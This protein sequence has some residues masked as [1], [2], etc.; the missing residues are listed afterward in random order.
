MATKR[1][2]KVAKLDGNASDGKARTDPKPDERV[3]A[4]RSTTGDLLALVEVLAGVDRI[5]V[6]QLSRQMGVPVATA[7]RMLRVLERSGFV[8]QL[9][10]SKEYRLTLKLFELGCQVASRTTMRDVAAVEIERLAQQTGTATNVGVLVDNYVLYLV[11]V[12]TDELI[13]LNLRPGSRAPA[14]CTAMGKA[15]LAAETRPLRA[16]VGDGPYAA[17]T[18]HSITTYKGL[19]AELEKVKRQGYAVDR[20]ELSLGLWCIAAPIPGTRVAQSGAVSVASYGAELSAEEC[21]RLGKL[22]V[23]CAA[24]IARRTEGLDDMHSWVVTRTSYPWA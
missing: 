12:E 7:Y 2:E 23:A 18:E 1:T 4:P 10:Q 22:V 14:T 9:S 11:K 19:A 13:T 21:D 16:I 15:M 20:Q 5:G 6:T 17:R 24:R 3:P 8:E